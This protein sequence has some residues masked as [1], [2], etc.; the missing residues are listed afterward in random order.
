MIAGLASTLPR[1]LTSG[2]RAQGVPPALAAHIGSLPPVSTLFS[3]LLGYNPVAS[4]L[5]PTGELAKLPPHNAAVLTGREFF[6]HLISGPFHH[7]LIIVFS[8]AIA[9]SVTGAIISLLRG[10]QFYYTEP[11]FDAASAHAETAAAGIAPAI[12]QSATGQRRTAA[13]PAAG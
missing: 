8:A 12:G 6:P 13:D 2:L 3:A 5:A 1:T 11:E 7:G 10:K 9:L 4:L